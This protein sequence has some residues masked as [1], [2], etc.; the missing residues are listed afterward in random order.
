MK[1]PSQIGTIHFV[2]IGGNGMSGIAEVM[3]NLG[4]RY[5]RVY[6]GGIATPVETPAP[7]PLAEEAAASS[8]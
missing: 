4:P 1:L 8:S 2:G 3:T 6:K 5:A 7:A